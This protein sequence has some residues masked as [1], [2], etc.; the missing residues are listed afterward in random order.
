MKNKISFFLF[1]ILPTM[2]ASIY[3]AAFATEQ[4]YVE[5]KYVI[6]EGGKIQVDLLGGLSSLTGGTSGAKNAYIAREYIWS[7]N[8]LKELDQDLKIREH[9]TNTDYDWWARLSSDANFRDF[10]D[11][12][13]DIIY[14]NHDATSGITTLGVTAFSAEKGY[15]IA[16]ELLAKA[17]AKI[18]N[19][20]DRSRNDSLVFAKQEL[21]NAELKLIEARTSV[22]VFRE[23]Q[24]EIDPEKT[25]QARLE[26]VA[27]LDSELATA[28][29][30]LASISSYL[31]SDSFKIRSQKNKIEVLK[32]QISNERK[33]WVRK[34]A[35][36][37]STT[38]SSLIGSY[39]KLLT[40]KTIAER[41]Y[42][43][44]LT[45]LESARLSAIQQQQYLEIISA[46]YFPDYSEKPD[47]FSGILS[48]LLGSFL[49]WAI[50]S[51]IISA[52]RDHV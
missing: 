2:I 26:I 51:L 50:G 21:R 6:Q 3:Y 19:L 12:W 36:G 11:Y 35:Q 33:R 23:Q 7:D 24:K 46:P 18:N 25:T 31:R 8:L 10:A 20:S 15:N 13:Y 17:E 14:I 40:K 52:V 38:L 16:K 9:Y 37:K 45:S 42:E 30:E 47:V 29:T 1:V 32:K 41:L 4:Y 44:A 39:E 49:L 5:T 27:N 43:S 28:E 48:V 34:G 22:T